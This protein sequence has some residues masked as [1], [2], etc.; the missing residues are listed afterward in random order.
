M[1]HKAL[2]LQKGFLSMKGSFQQG[3]VS[4]DGVR[5]LGRPFLLKA[6]LISSLGFGGRQED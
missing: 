3:A 1:Y 4:K 5:P 2:S 6:G